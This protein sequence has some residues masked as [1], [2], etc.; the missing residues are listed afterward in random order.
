[1][2]S[3]LVH[4]GVEKT[5][6]KALQQFMMRNTAALARFGVVFPQTFREGSWHRELFE[7]PAR[8][9]RFDALRDEIA[10]AKNALLSYERA[11]RAPDAQLDRLAALGGGLGA[12]I[13]V[14]P[15]TELYNSALNQ[16]Y[17]AHRKTIADVEA[18]A[19]DNEAVR[20]RLD[21]NAQARRWE[22]RLGAGRL[23]VR[24]YRLSASPVRDALRLLG[25]ADDA[26][27]DF[28][29][30]ADNPNRAAD[31]RS[32]RVLRAL[33]FELGGDRDRLLRAVGEAHRV[34]SADWIDTRAR[35]APRLISATD[36]DRLRALYAE[37]NAALCARYGLAP[38]ELEAA[39]PAA[40]EDLTPGPE[41]VAAARAIIAAAERKR[42]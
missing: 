18:F 2:P 15:Q 40:P 30:P 16:H 9:A 35:P 4:I 25:V 41:D 37:G 38:L 42:T 7:G 33:K 22:R 28:E 27:G 3:I 12:L 23:H 8:D 5:G 11:Y 24:R 21:L 34:L 13:F 31:I 32:L 1:M 19:L 17:K 14:R 6:S 10:G 36:I 29:W 20:A 26:A 39:P